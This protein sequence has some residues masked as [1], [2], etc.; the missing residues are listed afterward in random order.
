MSSMIARQQL[1]KE[2]MIQELTTIFQNSGLQTAPEKIQ[3]EAP[4]KYLGWEITKTTITPQKLPIRTEIATLNDVQKLVGDLNW[5]CN[6]CG[7]TN[8]DLSPLVEL[9]RGD[10]DLNSP[11]HLTAEA[12]HALDHISS[13][14][15]QAYGDRIIVDEDIILA[16]INHHPYPCAIIM[17]W[18]NETEPLK[19]L[20]WV[21][22]PFQTKKTI[23]TR[24][25][26]FATLIMKGREII[27]DI[28]GIEPAT[29][30]LPLQKN[31]IE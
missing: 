21:F 18:L 4:W 13:K 27:I 16:I 5:V 15:S 20:E 12:Q 22:L 19:I 10:G 7:I 14:V 30:L 2:S 6:I 28:A 3:T 31:H 9:L 23:S 17:Q 24:I 11:R 8:E 26:S 25:E 1:N 29:I